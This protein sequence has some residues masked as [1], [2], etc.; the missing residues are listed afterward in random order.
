MQE[1]GAKNYEWGKQ[2]VYRTSEKDSEV[3]EVLT[4]VPKLNG[5]WPYIC[6]FINIFIPGFG[7]MISLNFNQIE[8]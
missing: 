3:W 6:L 7:T 8:F 2:R 1:W 5:V 4:D